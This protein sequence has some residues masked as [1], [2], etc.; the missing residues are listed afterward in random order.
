MSK[1]AWAVA[2]EAASCGPAERSKQARGDAG[3][4]SATGS[5][6]RDG[7]SCR[8]RSSADQGWLPGGVAV[9][10]PRDP[11]CSVVELHDSPS[12]P[13]LPRG[14]RQVLIIAW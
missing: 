14:F 10:R 4:T 9:G 13:C 5:Q 1:P 8:L 2:S 11:A 7:L 6:A 12:L 3:S